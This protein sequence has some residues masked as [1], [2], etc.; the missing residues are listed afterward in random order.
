MESGGT[1]LPFPPHVVF[2]EVHS[3]AMS[4]RVVVGTGGFGWARRGG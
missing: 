4:E 3:L 1:A 2:L